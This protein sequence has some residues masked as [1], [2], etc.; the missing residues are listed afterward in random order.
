MSYQDPEGET[1][2]E[3]IIQRRQD[4]ILDD[5]YACEEPVN[6][7]DVFFHH[8]ADEAVARAETHPETAVVC[9]VCRA[10][11]IHVRC[12]HGTD[13]EIFTATKEW[14]CPNCKNMERYVFHP[15]NI[16]RSQ[17]SLDG[18]GSRHRIERMSGSGSMAQLIPS[19]NSGLFAFLNAMEQ[20]HNPQMSLLN[21]F[22]NVDLRG[23]D[24]NISMRFISPTRPQRPPAS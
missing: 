14:F 8:N 4:D 11:L 10:E 23:R 3:V 12:M 9:H 2:E 20:I 7:A 6:R 13:K 17:N 18:P 24:R 21:S 22:L 5:C 19:R 1:K 16:I 15:I